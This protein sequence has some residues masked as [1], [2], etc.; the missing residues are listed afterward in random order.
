MPGLKI[1]TIAFKKT[2]EKTVSPTVRRGFAQISKKTA[3]WGIKGQGDLPLIMGVLNFGDPDHRVWNNAQ[4]VLAPIPPRPWLN[5]STQGIYQ[6]KINSYIRENLPRVIMSIQ[7]RGQSSFR[8][9]S[10]QAHKTLH[11]DDFIAGLAKIGRDNARYA[12]EK[13][14]FQENAE[15]TL[16]HKSDPR[17][18]HGHGRMKESSITA[19]TDKGDVK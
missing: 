19:W 13:A 4:G 9:T 7:T 8:K 17:P 1:N 2:I 11:P 12:W 14:N 5:R 16:A 15:M 3:S 6:V 18:L 10:S